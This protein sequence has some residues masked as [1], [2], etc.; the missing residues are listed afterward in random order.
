M[1]LEQRSLDRAIA[2]TLT[3]IVFLGA[4]WYCSVSHSWGDDFAAYMLQGKALATGTVEKQIQ[5]NVLLHPGE[6]YGKNA[7]GLTQLTYVWGFPIQLA[8]LYQLVGFDAQVPQHLLYYKIPGCLALAGTAGILFLFFRKRFRQDVSALLSVF[9]VISI[10]PEVNNI[11][12]DL[13]FL[14]LTYCCFYLYETLWERTTQKGFLGHACVLGICLWYT[15]LLRLNGITVVGLIGAMH[16]YKL[17]SEPQHRVYQRLHC[18]PYV[19]FGLLLAVFYLFFPRVTSNS[20]DIG[21]GALSDGLQTNWKELVT[22]LHSSMTFG[23]Q[24]F[25]YAVCIG[26][27]LCFCI[28]F[29]YKGKQEFGYAAF[30]VGTLLITALLPYS[31]GLRYLFGMLPLILMFMGYGI[32]FLYKAVCSYSKKES[33]IRHFTC[34]V[35][36]CVCIFAASELYVNALVIQG[37]IRRNEILISDPEENAY[38]EPCL[39]IYRFIQ[40]ETAEDA[41]FAFWKPRALYL[42]T[43]RLAF[44]PQINGHEIMDADYFLLPKLQYKEDKMLY[45]REE[46]PMTLIYENEG[47]WLYKIQE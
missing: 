14:C 23:P 47:F 24:I 39:D 26:L 16:L 29:L 28:G 7:Q 25:E 44:R 38:A 36:L 2:I 33:S 4:F 18:I 32:L 11:Q 9:L 3:L 1:N 19:V 40:T 34:L 42:N 20:G 15:Y 8:V 5:E 31:Q 37:Q 30:L 17:L 12:T 6:L 21:L 41:L 27:G 35:T 10:L 46:N 13:P 45:L 22:W 43:G